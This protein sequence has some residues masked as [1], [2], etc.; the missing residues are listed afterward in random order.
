MKC[1]FNAQC[2]VDSNYKA[3]CQC[4]KC[5]PITKRVCGSDGR[6]YI[7][8]C[9]LRRESCTTKTNI[10]VLHD[11]K[12]SKF[13]GCNKNVFPDAQL[14]SRHITILLSCYE[15]SFHSSF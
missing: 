9:E 7:N 4:P 10:R 13:T 2:V 14:V 1:F 6:T 5:P 12:C 3:S 15:I 8:E 11:G